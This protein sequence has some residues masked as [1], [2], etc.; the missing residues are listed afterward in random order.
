MRWDP[1]LIHSCTAKTTVCHQLR[2]HLLEDSTIGGLLVRPY[3][4][5]LGHYLNP[6]PIL[7]AKRTTINSDISC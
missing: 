2:Y 5:L 4:D 7:I 1:T 6:V 3:Y